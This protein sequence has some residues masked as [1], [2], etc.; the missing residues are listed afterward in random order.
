MRA[1]TAKWRQL[2]RTIGLGLSLVC[3]ARPILAQSSPATGTSGGE[4]ITRPHSPTQSDRAAPSDIEASA[5]NSVGLAGSQSEGSNPPSDHDDGVTW[6]PLVIPKTREEVAT[7]DR[8][9]GFDAGLMAQSKGRRAFEASLPPQR[10]SLRVGLGG[11]YVQGADGAAELT[12]VGAVNGVDIDLNTFLTIGPRGLEI[13]SGRLFLIDPKTERGLE[14][15]DVFTELRG[16]NR[17]V[18]Y[19]WRGRGGRRPA[20]SLYVPR[21]QTSGLSTAV[22]YRDEAVLFGRFLAG[23]ELASDGSYFVKGQVVAGRMNVEGSFRSAVIGIPRIQDSGFFAS[24]DIWR[25]LALQAGR[26]LSTTPTE[27]SDWRSVGI[28]VPVANRFNLTLE[29]SDTTTNQSQHPASGAMLDLPLGPVR[30]MQRYQWGKFEYVRPTGSLLHDQRQLQSVG[31]YSP[32]RWASLGLQVANQWQPDGSIRQWEELRTSIQVSP[33]TELQAFTAFPDF[34]DPTQFRLHLAQQLPRRF[35]LVAEYGRLSAFQ[36]VPTFD[37]ERSRLKVLVRKTWDVA[38]PAAGADVRGRV[39]DQLGWPVAGTIVRL[40]PYHVMSD[41]RGQYAFEHLP[42]GEL[43]LSLDPDT[44]PANYVSD[45]NTSRLSVTRTSRHVVDLVVVPLNAIRGRVYSDLN[46]NGKYDVGEQVSS[47]VIR[48]GDRATTTDS[49]GTYGFY[50]LEPGEYE[51]RIDLTRLSPEYEPASR[52]EIAVTLSPER[53][54]TG[55]DF[56][57]ARK[58]RKVIMQNW[59]GQ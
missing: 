6:R 14:L 17:G 41:D 30:F 56:Q 36:S 53:A 4:S 52:T 16:L 54:A 35:A 37:G 43:E 19:S 39:V 15:G 13:Y 45:G 57:L 26:R 40:G 34:L 3:D 2:V 11:G 38:T 33:R 21:Y 28:R 31:S 50:N 55:T 1:R 22:A 47:V 25:G 51:V 42:S 24:Y 27:W 32:T 10:D 44:I 5:L 18:R 48:L 46:Q 58:Q 12:G 9:Y 20:V 8:L 59:P 49:D 23:G 7:Y 29:H